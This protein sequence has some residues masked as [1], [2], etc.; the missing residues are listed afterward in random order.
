MEDVISAFIPWH[1]H[2][3]VIIVSSE[4]A[5]RMASLGVTHRMLN[6]VLVRASVVDRKDTYEKRSAAL[7]ALFVAMD[8]I[9]RRASADADVVKMVETWKVVISVFEGMPTRAVNPAP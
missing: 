6:S 2:G 3:Y 1:P 4:C 9:S 5:A 7:T 8:R